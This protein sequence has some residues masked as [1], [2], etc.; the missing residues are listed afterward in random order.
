MKV[1][2]ASDSHGLT[3]ELTNLV[4][5]Y[6]DDVQLFIH[7]GDSELPGS[8]EEM[9]SFHA[10]K[11][12]CDS[13]SSGYPDDL[14][15]TVGGFKLFVTHGHLYNI[16]MSP[17]NL[18]YKAEETGADIVCFGHTHHAV[19]FQEGKKIFINPGSLR[20]P[21]GMNEK[22]YVI[23][24]IN[25]DKKEVN[26]NYFNQNGEPVESLSKKYVLA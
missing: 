12:N 15:K 26:V 11:G 3:H 2:I 20:L 21:R 6:R 7:C 1:L 4:E 13:P 16:K 19:T 24:E 23:C 22:T 25:N 8:S 10:V 17:V 5:R 14:I 9:T 18:L